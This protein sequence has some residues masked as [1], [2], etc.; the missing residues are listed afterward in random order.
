[1]RVVLRMERQGIRQ[2]GG[3][4]RIEVTNPEK[5]KVS[6]GDIPEEEIISYPAEALKLLVR[7]TGLQHEAVK[8]IDVMKAL[9][10][11][12]DVPEGLLI[13]R[14]G[15]FDDRATAFV[16]P[17][18]IVGEIP[19]VDLILDPNLHGARTGEQGTLEGWKREVAALA[20]K[21]PT[22][23]FAIGVMCA[24]VFHPFRSSGAESNIL[25][26]FAGPTSIGKTTVVKVG[27]SV[28]GPVNADPGQQGSFLETWLATTNAL[29]S[30]FAKHHHIGI[31]LDE[32][33]DVQPREIQLICYKVAGGRGKGRLSRDIQQRQNFE[34]NCFGISTGEMTTVERAL[35][36]AGGTAERFLDGGAETRVVNLRVST[37]FDDLHG[38]ATA[39][40]FID[41]LI[42]GWSHNYGVA[43]PALV[44][45]LI[46]HREEVPARLKIYVDAWQD[47]VSDLLPND[48]PPENQRVIK[49]FGTIAAYA[50]LAADVLELPWPAPNETAEWRLDEAIGPAGRSALFAAYTLLMRWLA[51]NN[52][53]V[54]S[55]AAEEVCEALRAQFDLPFRWRCIFDGKEPRKADDP[56]VECIGTRYYQTRADGKAADC[57]AIELYPDVA[58]RVL[59]VPRRQIEA[60]MRSL[61][62]LGHLE[63]NEP[64][65]LT[66]RTSTEFYETRRRLYRIKANLFGFAAHRLETSY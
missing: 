22:L 14:T 51:Q 18:R 54:M 63:T 23:M 36:G 29:E 35:E 50:A 40:A 31:I 26:H 64:D 32:L 16:L 9:Y 48:L 25:F 19:G 66:F 17:H 30:T 61:H 7:Q 56:H 1:M 24:S 34:W 15:W 2:F 60:A 41:Q 47:N 59:K 46:A 37:V 39:K 45:W 8:P 42:K 52:A 12:R 65:R 5:G 6:C 27:G 4:L 44:E 55:A 57:V 13:T 20:Q 43:G 28:W 58:A 33:A 38:H 11:A 10:P 62:R 3:V 21:N 49:H 53:G